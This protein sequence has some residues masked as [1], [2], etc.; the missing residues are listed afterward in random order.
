[1]VRARLDPRRVMSV[2]HSRDSNWRPRSVTIVE[3]TPKREIQP[4]R[5]AWATASAV[6]QVRGMASVGPDSEDG[7]VWTY[8]DDGIELSEMQLSQPGVRLLH[9]VV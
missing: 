9:G 2:F 7:G 1:M 4:V 8:C 6:I 5:K 3:G